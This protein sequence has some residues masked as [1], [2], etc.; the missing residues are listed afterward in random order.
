MQFGKHA[1]ET[2]EDVVNKDIQW[3]VDMHATALG[4]TKNITRNVIE[5]ARAKGIAI[6]EAK[7]KSKP[8]A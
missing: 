2:W 4:E 6:P 1:S 5:Y 3:V 7:P 8:S